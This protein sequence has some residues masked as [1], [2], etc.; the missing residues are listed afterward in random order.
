VDYLPA[1]IDLTEFRTFQLLP[2]STLIGFSFV[3]KF[4][5]LPTP[6]SESIPRAE[7]EEQVEVLFREV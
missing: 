4:T 6:K 5:T 2:A 1:S 3:G 7:V